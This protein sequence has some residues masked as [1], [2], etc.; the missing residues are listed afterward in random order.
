MISSCAVDGEW[1]D[2][3][4]WSECSKACG[5]GIMTRR[6]NCTNPP[7]SNGGACC[8]GDNLESESCNTNSCSGNILGASLSYNTDN[9]DFLLLLLSS[10]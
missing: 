2:F 3:G 7:P 6:R 10:F 1:S 5:G 9:A 4:D 8:V